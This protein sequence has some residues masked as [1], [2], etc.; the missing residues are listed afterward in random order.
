MTWH[1]VEVKRADESTWRA[2]SRHRT[3][4]AA[5]RAADKYAAKGIVRARVVPGDLPKRGPGRPALSADQVR[6]PV[7]VRLSPEMRL[8]LDVLA[9]HETRTAVIERLVAAEIAKLG[10]T[11]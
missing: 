9:A 3:H 5:L 1:R 7:T 11:R 2:A 10:G 8:A 4:E 6:R